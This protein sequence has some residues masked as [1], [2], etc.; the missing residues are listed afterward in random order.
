MAKG[1]PPEIS[2]SRAQPAG[3]YVVI[4]P[5]AWEAYV[6][7]DGVARECTYDRDAHDAPLTGLFSSRAAA[8]HALALHLLQSSPIDWEDK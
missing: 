6:W 2:Y 3:R 8:E 1:D 5:S 7:T 4:W